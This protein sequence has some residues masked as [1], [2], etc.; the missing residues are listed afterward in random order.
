MGLGRRETG[1]EEVA[2]AC[3]I[4]PVTVVSSKP[5]SSQAVCA[6]E[7]TDTVRHQH[8]LLGQE[9]PRAFKSLH[10]QVCTL[11]QVLA[12]FHSVPAVESEDPQGG[13]LREVGLP[14]VGCCE[15]TVAG[16]WRPQQGWG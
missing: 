15:V 4:K 2:Q 6:S 3:V 11:L 14:E 1:R 5:L 7:G 13:E 8:P 9:L 12:F 10:F 16:S